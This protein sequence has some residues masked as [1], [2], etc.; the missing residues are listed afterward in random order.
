MTR[1]LANSYVERCYSQVNGSSTGAAG[2]CAAVIWYPPAQDKAKETS[3]MPAKN[4]AKTTAAR[5]AKA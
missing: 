4:S 3:L 2:P 1:T 5:N